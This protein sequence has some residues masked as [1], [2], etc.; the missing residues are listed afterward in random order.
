MKEQT[1]QPQIKNK[2]NVNTNSANAN[3]NFNTK[4]RKT[5]PR[6]L[7]ANKHIRV[8]DTDYERMLQYGEV[9]Q[10]LYIAFRRCLD[11]AA[12][13]RQISSEKREARREARNNAFAEYTATTSKENVEFENQNGVKSASTGHHSLGTQTPE[14]ET[15]STVPDLTTNLVRDESHQE[16][17]TSR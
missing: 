14:T 17:P 13:A 12:K 11:E 2:Q 4:P 5:R 3:A 9:G 16:I 7:V 10:P 1:S 15:F 8:A 6:G